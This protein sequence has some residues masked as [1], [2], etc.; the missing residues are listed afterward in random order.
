[1]IRSMTAYGRGE[2]QHGDH[3]FMAEIRTINH[4]Y[5]DV[6]LRLPKEAQSLEGDLKNRIAARIRRGRIDAVLQLTRN[7]QEAPYELELNVPLMRAYLKIVNQLSEQFGVAPEIT[8]ESLL[9]MKD[10]IL[11]QPVRL[12]ED[13]LRR[14]FDDALTR[15]LDALDEMRLKEGQTLVADFRERLAAIEDY[16]H[17]TAA[18]QP[19]LVEEYRRRLKESLQRLLEA[20]VV[21]EVRLA[22][23]VAFM[24]ERAD[25]TEETVRIRSHLEQFRAYLEQDEP[26]GRRLDF[27]LQ[28]LNREVNTMGSKASDAAVAKMVV[29]MKAELEKLREQVQNVE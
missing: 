16:A 8:A 1:M 12:D 17:R 26:Q 27:L 5:R 10:I 6:N 21:D 7:G 14:G 13:L 20:P 2:V 29:E 28:E 11:Y 23:E 18:R 22:Q 4:R 19:A 3:L 9:Q 25:F 24:A 15:A